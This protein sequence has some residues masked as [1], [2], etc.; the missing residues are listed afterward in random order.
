MKI[1]II[2]TGS[3]AALKSAFIID[4]LKNA[5][6]NV[7]VITSKS[8]EI[9]K[10][11]EKIKEIN[12]ITYHKNDDNEEYELKSLE[13]IKDIDILCVIPSS[14]NFI[15]KVAN[16]ICDN[17]VTSCFINYQ[18][19]KM[20]CPAMNSRMWNNPI[21]QENLNKLDNV[22]VI[23]PRVGL[24]TSGAH[25]IGVLEHEHLIIEQILNQE[26]NA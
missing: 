22:L 23:P 13:I 20:I 16:G 8:S 14:Y 26:K 15:G 18:G 21:L 9:F 12:G 24:L 11:D 5:T 4:E 25:A 10:V 6:N 2:V 17:L 7:V 3:N 1:L 19:R